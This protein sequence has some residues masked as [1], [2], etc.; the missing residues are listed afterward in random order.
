MIQIACVTNGV[1]AVFRRGKDCI[2]GGAKVC[3]FKAKF[4]RIKVQKMQKSDS[5][6]S[7]M[8]IQMNEFGLKRCIKRAELEKNCFRKKL[9]SRIHG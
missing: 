5:Y 8:Q 1:K 3:I 4:Y 9:R 2:L 6:E 7:I